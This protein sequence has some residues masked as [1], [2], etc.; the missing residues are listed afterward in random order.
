MCHRG[1]RVEDF[2]DEDELAEAAKHSLQARAEYDT[3]GSTAAEQA[4]AAAAAEAE[5]SGRP[6]AF[7][8]EEIIAPVAD[9]WGACTITGTSCIVLPCSAV[10]TSYH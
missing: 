4:R 8:P 6:F 5:T 3:F 9:S 1:Q 10:T 7:V 2:F